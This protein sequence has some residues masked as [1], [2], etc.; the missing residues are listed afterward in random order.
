MVQFV[1]QLSLVVCSPYGLQATR[2]Q[3]LARKDFEINVFKINAKVTNYA[4]ATDGSA[5]IE[6]KNDV[7]K[8]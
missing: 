3:Y 6:E 8:L 2:K 1:F 7:F 4:S 5:K